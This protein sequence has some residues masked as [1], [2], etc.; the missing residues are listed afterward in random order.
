MFKFVLSAMIVISGSMYCFKLS[1]RSLVPSVVEIT[2]HGERLRDLF[3]LLLQDRVVILNGPVD[4]ISANLINAQLLYLDSADS[5]ADIKFYIHSNGGSA[6]AALSIYDIMQHIDADVCTIGT[7]ICASAGALLLASGAEGKRYSVPNTRIMIHQPNG[8]AQ[9]QATDID[10]QAKEILY[11]K[12]RQVEILAE[13]T[14]KDVEQL[15]EDTERDKYLSAEEALE[16]KLID[17]V[18]YPSDD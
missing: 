4:D 7:G 9:G 1:A 10:I 2:Q 8:G 16:Y 11:L 13:H 15:L 6:Y 18:L 17:K 3:S 12:R 5:E 14:G